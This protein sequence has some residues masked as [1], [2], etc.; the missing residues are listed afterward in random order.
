MAA[1][2][3]AEF[4]PCLATEPDNTMT[5][6][7]L[8]CHQCG[9]ETD[10]VD[11]RLLTAFCGARC[12]GEN[13]GS[14]EQTVAR[15][16]GYP[17]VCA[18]RGGCGPQY[19]PENTMAAFR[20]SVQCGTRLLELDLHLSRDGHL[21][22]MH[23][24]TVEQTTDG[25]GRIGEL[26][27]AQLQQLDAGHYLAEFRGRG[28][29]V[30][31]FDEFLREFAPVADLLFCLDFKEPEAARAAMRAIE[32]YRLQHRVMLS[33]VFTE[34][35]EA[36]QL[37]K[38]LPAVPLAT[39]IVET[40]KMLAMYEL[41]LLAHYTPKHDVYGF[42]LCKPTL[43]LWKPELVQAVHSLG[44]R[45]IVFPWGDELCK[46]ERMRECVQFGVDYI[47]VDRPDLMHQVLLHEHQ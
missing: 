31:S 18:H 30:P 8:H 39:T 16:G 38:P 9:G 15:T 4:S 33:S 27:L 7:K 34:A 5:T 24:D 35:N 3:K 17:L 32:P 41:G 36:L 43:G 11:P 40:L 47:M 12:Q 10:Q 29:R 23:W 42:V 21:V 45:M 1:R 26:T 25:A 13:G 2:K 20:R 22:L 28:H 44:C 37:A 19:A 46:P 6:T 14:F